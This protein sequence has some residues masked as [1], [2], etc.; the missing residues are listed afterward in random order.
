MIDVEVIRLRRL[1][2]TALWVRALAD[3][4]ACHS[5][6]RDSIFSQSGRSCWRIARLITGRLRAHPYLSYQRGPSEVRAAYDRVSAG[7]LSGIAQYRGRSLQVFSTELQRVAREM[8]D[9]R[10]LTW[11]ADLS[12]GLGRLQAEFRRLVMEVNCAARKEAGMHHPTTVQ[13]ELRSAGAGDD[14]RAV[15]AHWPYLGL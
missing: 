6:R 12:E 4:M 9:T 11:S 13:G 8:D 10:A 7:L 2:N 14:S 1:R 15:A 5:V 3:A